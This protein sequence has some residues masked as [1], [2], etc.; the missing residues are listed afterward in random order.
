MSSTDRSQT[1]RLRRRKAQIQ[2]VARATC[3][4]CPEEGPQGPTDQ[5]TWLS[6]RFGQMA[7]RKQIATGAIVEESCCA[8]T[9]GLTATFCGQTFTLSLKVGESV[10]LRNTLSVPIIFRPT[11]ELSIIS[12]SGELITVDPG[13]TYTITNSTSDNLPL[14]E[15]TWLCI[16]SLQTSP[17]TYTVNNSGAY[18]NNSNADVDVIINTIMYTVRTNRAVVPLTAGM[19]YTVL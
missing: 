10:I 6:R 18:K 5:S 7:Y 19:T 14:T 4:S 16:Y 13:S 12:T 17:G 8:A 11:A 15:F 3:P 1:E 9:D 2:A